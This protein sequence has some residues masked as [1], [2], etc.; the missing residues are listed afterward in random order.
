MLRQCNEPFVPTAPKTFCAL[1]KA[2]WA[3][4]ADLTSVPG[5]LVCN[6]NLLSAHCSP[7]L[8]LTEAE[9][10]RFLYTDEVNIDS[11]NVA[12]LHYLADRFKVHPCSVSPLKLLPQIS[13]KKKEHKSEVAKKSVSARPGPILEGT[14]GSR[15]GPGRAGMAPT[16]GPGWVRNTVK[17]S[18]WRIWMGPPRTRDGTWT[19][20]G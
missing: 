18:T 7:K 11:T 15:M 19:G 9:F 20:P 16:S 17:Q 13:G 12:A 1:P 10:L 14:L 2:L 5:G 8:G 4:S 3:T 6:L